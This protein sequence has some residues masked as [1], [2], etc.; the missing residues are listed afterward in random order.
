M[1]TLPIHLFLDLSLVERLLPFLRH[2]SPAFKTTHVGS[3][4]TPTMPLRHQ[5]FPS[6]PARPPIP[7]TRSSSYVLD[8]LDAQASSPATMQ[9]AAKSI[10]VA[11]I[12][13]PLLRLSVRCPAPPNRRGTWGD[14]AHLRSGI[15][16]LD[17]HTL[18]ASIASSPPASI[19]HRTANAVPQA[20]E[21]PST[22]VQWKK[23]M[24]FF[25]RVPGECIRHTHI[26]ASSLMQ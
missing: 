18:R 17:V 11:V 2:I 21:V 5:V 15:V 4:A 1:E 14:G 3:P 12:S 10:H 22:S 26:Y 24:L 6:K 13:C 25:N 8:D 20:I 16:T 7:P 23:M 9:P 19:S